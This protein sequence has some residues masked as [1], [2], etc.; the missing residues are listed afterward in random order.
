M[1]FRRSTAIALGAAALLAT[2][3]ATAH[4]GP[5]WTVSVGGSST[6]APATFTATSGP[7]DFNVPGLSLGCDYATFDGTITPGPTMSKAGE[8]TGSEFVN[9]FGPLGVA[10]DVTQTSVWDINIIGDN[11]GGI[12]PGQIGNVS[13]TASNPDGLCTFDIVGTKAGFIDENSQ[14]IGSD[15]T[16]GPDTLFVENVDG[17]YGLILEGDPATVK[18]TYELD[19]IAP[20][21]IT[22]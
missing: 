13:A 16:T 20:V 9:C 22:T 8:V 18:A 19:G 11:S 2:T 1:T 21:T 4:A 7:L 10:F 17:C 3:A 14:L 12:T 5:P 15:N 6:G